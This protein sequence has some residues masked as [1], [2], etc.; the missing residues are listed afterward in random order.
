MSR[1]YGTGLQGEAVSRAALVS[2]QQVELSAGQSK[3]IDLPQFRVSAVY[4]TVF[5]GLLDLWVG[6]GSAVGSR[7]M[8]RIGPTGPRPYR[9]VLPL[10]SYSFTVFA[11][12][13]RD[14]SASMVMTNG[15]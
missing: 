6:S 14:L 3:Q 5:D 1:G 15:D 10:Q 7:P 2:Y 8:W 12:D 4:I 9:L 13:G 11:S